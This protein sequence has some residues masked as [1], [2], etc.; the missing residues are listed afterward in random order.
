MRLLETIVGHKA[1]GNVIV[2]GPSVCVCTCICACTHM[3]FPCTFTARDWGKAGTSPATGTPAQGRARSP[4]RFISPQSVPSMGSQPF[5]RQPSGYRRNSGTG[6]WDSSL[7]STS[8]WHQYLV[9]LFLNFVKRGK[10]H[11]QISYQ[12]LNGQICFGIQNFQTSEMCFFVII[13]IIFIIIRALTFKCRRQLTNH[14]MKQASHLTVRDTSRA[15]GEAGT[16]LQKGVREASR[17]LARTVPQGQGRDSY[18]GRNK[19]CDGFSLECRWGKLWQLLG[20][21]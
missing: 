1:P 15:T 4:V 18:T 14:L 8:H 19:N 5:L 3:C 12:N 7:G 16:A 2:C 9:S 20:A 6:F 17:R 11:I 21:R 13:I 10:T